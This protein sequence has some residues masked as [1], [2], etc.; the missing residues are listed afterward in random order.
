MPQRFHLLGEVPQHGR[1]ARRGHEPKIKGGRQGRLAAIG[2]RIICG[3]KKLRIKPSFG[4][5]RQRGIFGCILRMA[6]K[7]GR[8]GHDSGVLVK[9]GRGRQLAG[10]FR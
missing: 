1:L 9:K 4:L 5:F 6:Q 10:R 8:L 3:V 2:I 7:R